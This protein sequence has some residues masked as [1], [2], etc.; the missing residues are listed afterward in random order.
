[1]R[2]TRQDTGRADAADDSDNAADGTQRHSFNQKLRQNIVAAR[3]DCH[4]HTDFAR[5]LGHADEHDVHDSNSADQQRY[6]CNCSQQ[7]SHDP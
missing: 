2:I 7:N 3:A 1:M 5:S 4:A 6:S